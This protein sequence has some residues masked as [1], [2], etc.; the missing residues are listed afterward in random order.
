M[1]IVDYLLYQSLFVVLFS[2]SILYF[3]RPLGRGKILTAFFLGFVG[4]LLAYLRIILIQLYQI[5]I[6]IR[7]GID[8]LDSEAILNSDVI[9]TYEFNIMGPLLS[10]LF[11]EPVRYVL[12]YF[13]LKTG[14]DLTERKHVPLVFG[15][16]W[17]LSE[18]IV[19]TVGIIGVP[20]F[21]LESFM[22]SAYERVIATIFHISMSYVVVYA[23]FDN[24]RSLW[25]A[26]V[27]HIMLNMVLLVMLLELRWLDTLQRLLVIE[28]VLTLVVAIVVFLSFRHVKAKEE[29]VAAEFGGDRA[30]FKS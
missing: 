17:S 21:P 15:L 29:I 8:F 2:L 13:V 19:L 26:V 23:K 14:Q 5:A 7:H 11:E 3:A 18:I 24:R 1:A 4:W 6:L 10:G 16:G 22:I 28:G 30:M 9:Y 12:I 27:A 25:L 20:E